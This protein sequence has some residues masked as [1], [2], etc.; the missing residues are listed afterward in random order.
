MRLQHHLVLALAALAL[1]A[2]QTKP[3]PVAPV[4]QPKPRAEAPATRTEA[5]V[6]VARSGPIPG[7]AADFAQN[8]GDRVYYAYDQYALSSAAQDTLRRQA[9]WLNAYPSTRVRVSGNCDERGT[10]EYNLALGS[11]RAQAS[12]NYLVNLGIAANRIDTISYGQERPIDPRAN[13]DGWA[14]NRN[15]HTEIVSGAVIG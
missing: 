3:A 5:P 4:E 8:V 15:A 1:A 10:R 12:K 11:K 6:E 9:A 2:C 13:E 14:V 7:S